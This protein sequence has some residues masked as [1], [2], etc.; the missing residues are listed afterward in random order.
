MHVHH[1]YVDGYRILQLEL[2]A[3][4]RHSPPNEP[5]V[6]ARAAHVVGDHVLEARAGC[7]V[8]G[9]HHPRCGTRHDRGH[10]GARGHACRHGTAV[11]P[12]DQHVAPV[13]PRGKLVGEAREVACEDRLHAGVDRGGG[14]A[15]VLAV[16][17][18]D[19]MTRG[20]EF[21]GPDPLHDSPGP[22]F[23]VR[24]AIR[25]QKV[26]HHRLASPP[27]QLPGCR[28]HRVLVERDLHAAARVHALRN[29]Q[30]QLAG[31]ERL[32][33]PGQSIGLRPGPAPELQHVPKSAGGD[34]AGGCELAFQQ[35]VGGGGRAVHQEVQRLEIHRCLLQGF[36]HSERLVVGCGRDLGEVHVARRLVQVEE[37][38]ERASDVHADDAMVHVRYLIARGAIS[39]TDV[40]M[41]SG[42][43]L[44]RSARVRGRADRR[45]GLRARA[46]ALER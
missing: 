25:V 44:T 32:E 7:G 46:S 39:G 26:D 19:F 12:H 23:V 37:V 21:V 34:Q 18:Q 16:L 22:S 14:A 28:R 1:R 43:G 2:R 20:D 10:R 11:S 27:E 9:G 4:R 38:G 13:G 31:D 36:Q 6:A 24:V 45:P 33:P 17:G 29:L 3:H 41:L 8:G 40:A 42:I 15:L 35:S 5:D 30:A